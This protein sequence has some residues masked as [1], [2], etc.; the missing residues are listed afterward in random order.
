MQTNTPVNSWKNMTGGDNNHGQ[1]ALT[2]VEE[3]NWEKAGDYFTLDCYESLG[4]SGFADRQLIANGLTSLL[5]ACLSFRLSGDQ[6]RWE[7]HCKQGILIVND[8][9]ETFF[10]DDIQKGLAHEVA[11]DFRTI[12]GLDGYDECYEKAMEYY[13][14]YEY[15]TGWMGEPEFVLIG[16]VFVRIAWSAEFDIDDQTVNQIVNQSLIKRIKYKRAYFTDIMKQI[17]QKGSFKF[18]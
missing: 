12:G 9:R 11:G 14:D 17:L 7:N 10:T 3:E 5:W 16:R 15:P 2:H 1:V 4:E 13:T 18:E 6:Q 8:L